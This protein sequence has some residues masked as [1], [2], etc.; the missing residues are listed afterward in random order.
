MKKYGGGQKIIKKAEEI[1]GGEFNEKLFRVQLSY[2]KDI[3]YTE[4]IIYMKGFE[5]KNEVIKKALINFSL[6]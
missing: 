1:F 5:T 4:K 3:D 2:S 6:S